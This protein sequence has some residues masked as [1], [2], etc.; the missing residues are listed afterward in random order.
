MPGEQPLKDYFLTIQDLLT[1][2]LY[3]A[4]TRFCGHFVVASA[5][6]HY[7]SDK[8]VTIYQQSLALAV[9]NE[10]FRMD[11]IDSLL[12]TKFACPNRKYPNYKDRRTSKPYRLK[13]QQVK[14]IWLVS[15][16]FMLVNPSLPVVVGTIL[17]TAFLSF[18]ILDESL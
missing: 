13:K 12:R 8:A 16:T 17:F 6:S 5:G 18:S 4:T 1:P 3:Y 15:G 11:L 10:G 14:N 7:L 2:A 9:L